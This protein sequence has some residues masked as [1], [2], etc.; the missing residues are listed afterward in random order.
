MKNLIRC[1]V[2]VGVLAFASVTNALTLQW[3]AVSTD[4]ANVPLGTG[5]QVTSYKV[6]KCNTPTASCLKAGATVIGTVTVP[7]ALATYSIS[8][9]AQPIPSTYFVTAVNIVTES[10]ES[11]SLKAIGSDKP[12]NLIFIQP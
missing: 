11:D 7:P 10:A 9:T 8:I 6:W 1:L 4:T 2:L 3:D 12:K 5:L